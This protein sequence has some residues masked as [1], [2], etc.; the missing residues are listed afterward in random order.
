MYKE[1]IKKYPSKILQQDGAGRH[2]SKLSQN[3]IKFLFKDKLIPTWDND[4]KISGE[5]V[6]RWPHSSPD[7]YPIEIIW[8]I[9][10]QMLLKIWII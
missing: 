5:Y 1:D 3:M 9:I 4:L 2:I 6:S 10:K 8:P 7:L